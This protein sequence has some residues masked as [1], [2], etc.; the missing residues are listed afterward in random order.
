MRCGGCYAEEVMHGAAARKATSTMM[1]AD[2]VY[3]LATQ[4]K[5]M[6]CKR[7]I[8]IGGEPTLHPSFVAVFAYGKHQLGLQMRFVTNGRAFSSPKFCESMIEAGL[9]TGDLTFSMHAPSDELS[10]EFVGDKN[11]F[12]QFDHG[13]H[14]LI[15]RGVVPNVNIALTVGL[16]PHIERM[17]RYLQESGLKKVAFNLGSPAVGANGPDV[18]HCIPPDQLATKVYELFEYGISIGM[19]T[20]Y[21]FLVPFCLLE[22]PK[23]R[24]LVEAGV[25]SSGCQIS[26]GGGVLFNKEGD[27][28]P[29]NHMADKVTLP[30]REVQEI[31]QAGKFDEFWNSDDMRSLRATTSVYRSEH[32]KTCSWFNMCGGGCS[33]FWTHYDPKRY[34]KGTGYEKPE[35]EI[36]ASV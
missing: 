18:S 4:L 15:N 7:A 22:Y 11:G 5:D 1:P 17:M 19:R 12:K 20:S 30:K 33:L 28:I 24:R 35:V 13:L 32:C 34:I 6:G 10:E 23:M 3:R 29:C 27:L 26:S 16:L 14:N 2:D 36:H 25:I 8:L 31:I 9:Q 21:L